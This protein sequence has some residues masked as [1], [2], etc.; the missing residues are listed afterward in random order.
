MYL[1]KK[2]KEERTSPSPESPRHRHNHHVLVLDL[3]RQ[4]DPGKGL[5]V[6]LKG[7]I[8][9]GRQDLHGTPLG[10]LHPLHPFHLH[11][12]FVLGDSA[13]ARSVLPFRSASPRLDVDRIGVH[14]L[15]AGTT[16]RG[17]SR[18]Q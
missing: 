9:L 4:E 2:Y 16:S 12:V 14:A 8:I 3:I 5:L 6:Q 17:T 15:G 18:S 7:V 10:P 11:P 13:L 1:R